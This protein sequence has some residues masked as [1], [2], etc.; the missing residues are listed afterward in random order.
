MYTE[1]VKGNE[2][3]GVKFVTND[4]IFNTGD[5]QTLIF[6]VDDDWN[7][8]GIYSDFNVYYI[9]S[10]GK[11]SKI[12]NNKIYTSENIGKAH[13]NENVLEKIGSDKISIKNFKLSNSYCSIGKNLEYYE[14]LENIVFK[15]NKK[16]FEKFLKNTMDLVNDPSIYGNF[17]SLEQLKIEATLFRELSTTRSKKNYHTLYEI[18]KYC[19]N[20]GLCTKGYEKECYRYILDKIIKENKNGTSSS[21]RKMEQELEALIENIPNKFLLVNELVT[22]LEEK[23]NAKY[24]LNS[25]EALL[26]LTNYLLNSNNFGD[27]I[28]RRVGKIQGFIMGDLELGNFIGIVEEIRRE[29]QVSSE[30]L[31]NLGDLGQYTS[32]ETLYYLFGE[33]KEELPPTIRLTNSRQLNDPLEGKILLDIVYPQNTYIDSDVSYTFISSATTSLDSLPMWKQYGQD[34]TGVSLTYS[35]TFLS[36]LLAKT[37]VELYKMCYLEE[38]D[39]KTRAWVNGSMNEKISDGIDK[40]KNIAEKKREFGRHLSSIIYLMKNMDYS[41]EEEYRMVVEL[42]SKNDRIVAEKKADFPVPFLYTY[43]TQKESIERLGVEYSKVRLGPKAI[44]IDFVRPYVK[45]VADGIKI[46]EKSKIKYR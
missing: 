5:K 32:L 7:D 40:L 15:N 17:D 43:V 1:Y 37:D 10:D 16:E 46:I 31:K 27:S 44:D 12:G 11:R 28:K 19:K 2:F 3:Q 45:F 42:P 22:Y 29:L 23:V 35:K 6:Y 30:D 9:D 18:S 13:L 36:N 39:G 14:N 4:Y 38:V 26:L 24:P 8:H 21:L 34:A 20:N 33:G 41:Y 25:L